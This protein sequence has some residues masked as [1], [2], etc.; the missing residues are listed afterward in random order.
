MANF[1]N[2]M[3]YNSNYKA[4]G[5]ATKPILAV[6]VLIVIAAMYFYFSAPRSVN[7]LGSATLKAIHSGNIHA[8]YDL[9]SASFKRQTTY[10]AYSA[11]IG[12]RPILQQYTSFSFNQELEDKASGTAALAG[13]LVGGDGRQA[14]IQ[15]IFSKEHKAWRVQGMGV[16]PT[17]KAEPKMGADSRDSTVKGIPASMKPPSN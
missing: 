5:S 13:I 2:K 3:N 8:A 16:I 15:F 1:N 12:Q 17:A 7:E 4:Q 6:L 9:T 10:E 14:R 11:F